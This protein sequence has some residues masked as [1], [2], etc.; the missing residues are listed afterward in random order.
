VK[1]SGNKEQMSGP[2]RQ[3]CVSP[4]VFFLTGFP[5]RMA[6]FATLTS[7]KDRGDMH[8][9]ENHC[10]CMFQV[11]YIYPLCIHEL[12]MFFIITLE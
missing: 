1:Q 8:E 11:C 3:K 5:H 9:N 10:S 2:W 4:L 12:R 7:Y 6:P